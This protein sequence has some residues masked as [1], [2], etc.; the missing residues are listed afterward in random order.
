MNKILKYYEEYIGGILFSIMF[1]TLVMQIFSRQILNRPLMW[2]EELAR[3]MFVYI[4]MIGIT[5]GVKYEQHVGIEVISDKFPPRLAKLMDIIKTVLTG[6]AIVLLI[7]IGFKITLRKSSLELISLGVS[8]GY[9]YA[10]LPIG[11][12]LMGIRYL[13][14]I[15]KKNFCKIKEEVGVN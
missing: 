6:V 8:S 10:A 2:T 7:F 3:L 9:L 5:L 11:G 15:Y 1:V 12:V 14:N 4:A 13:E